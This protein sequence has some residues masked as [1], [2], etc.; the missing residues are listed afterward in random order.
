MGKNAR[1]VLDA[2]FLH[3]QYQLRGIGRYGIELFSRM[4]RYA[5][6]GGRDNLELHILGFEQ[7]PDCLTRLGFT[8][9]EVGEVAVGITFH[10]L[11]N[12]KASSPIA[13]IV[14][15]YSRVR[16]I[17]IRLKPD[18]YF[19]VHFER[20]LPTNIAPTVLPIHDV[21]PLATGKF[22]Q[23]G[24]FANLIKGAYYRR[25]LRRANKAKLIFTPSD[26][27]KL[28]ILKY[29]NI[30][31]AIVHTVHLGVS[32]VFRQDNLTADQYPYNYVI[33]DSGLEANKNSN[34]LLLILAKVFAA[35]P[36]LKLVITGGDFASGSTIKP[37]NERSRAFMQTAQNLGIAQHIV[38]VGRVSDNQLAQILARASVYLNVSAYEG[39]GLGPLQAMAAG[40]PAVTSNLSCFPEVSGEAALQIDPY[41]TQSAA[42]EIIDLLNNPEQR[43]D[44]IKKGLE[45]SKKFNWDNTFNQTWNLIQT[46]VLK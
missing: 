24:W 14:L 32:E 44:M 11:G 21:I 23:K 41:N 10:S 5:V 35:K 46:E 25:A 7:L 3:D 6:S 31:N 9:S 42:Q 1:I 18:M 30:S 17:V 36:E 22:S 2:T 27:S 15:Y 12:A 33:Y 26:F 16:P 8:E 13:N 28:D 40:V 38:P 45:Y 19:A 20:L 43:S 4:V 39:F 34:Q 37:L 29:T